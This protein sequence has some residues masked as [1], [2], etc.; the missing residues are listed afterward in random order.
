MEVRLTFSPKHLGVLLPVLVLIV[1]AGCSPMP[2]LS[3]VTAEQAYDIGVAALASEDYFIAIEAFRRVVDMYP[4]APEADDALLGLADSHRE[5]REYAL[6]ENEYRRLAAEY[7]DSPVV[8]EAQFKLAVTYYEQSRP[9]SLDQA[10]TRRAL[11]QLNR[12][13]GTYP[14][15]P[16]AVEARDLQAELR[17]RLAEKLWL[18]ADLYLSLDDLDAAAVYFD[19]IVNEYPDT[20]WA[21]RALETWERNLREAGRS[22]EA[23]E[24]RERFER[25]FPDAAGDAP[26][27]S[28]SGS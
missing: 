12:F 15:S 26:T 20:P 8:A 24:I 17:S 3:E 14:E 18:A 16:F 1:A 10:M 28:E 5:I 4:L 9:A 22:A 25:L 11:G 13:L 27:A 2:E 6:A 23:D 7:P 19:Q 21:P